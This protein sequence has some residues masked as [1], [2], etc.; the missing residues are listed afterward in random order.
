MIDQ[1]IAYRISPQQKRLWLLQE[2]GEGQPY[3]AQCAVLVEGVTDGAALIRALEHTI[4]RSDILRT[5]FQSSY[6]LTVPVQVVANVGLR[7]TGDFDLRCLDEGERTRRIEEALRHDWLIPFDCQRGPVVCASLMTLYEDRRLLIIT[8]PSLCADSIGMTNLVRELSYWYGVALDSSTVPKQAAEY[9]LFS[10]WQ[11]ELFETEDVEV[12]KSFWRQQDLSDLGTLRLPFGRQSNPERG[13]VPHLVSRDLGERLSAEIASAAGRL[14]IP[15]SAFL[16][17]C[18]HALLG[19]LTE[20]NRILVGAGFSGRSDEEVLEAVGLFAKYLPTRSDLRPRLGV[21]DLSKEI[22]GLVQEIEEWQEW[23]AWDH[24]QERNPEQAETSFFPLCYD[25]DQVPPGHC[26]SGA[27]FSVDKHYSC[28]DRFELKLRCVSR[29]GKLIAEF[30]YNSALYNAA[31]IGILAGQYRNLVEEAADDPSVPI[32]DINLVTDGERRQLLVDFNRAVAEYARDECLHELFQKQVRRVP[33]RVAAVYEDQSLSY[34]ALNRQ[35]NLL[36]HR[37][38]NMGVVPE[39]LVG[40]WVERSV[41]LLVGVI[42]IVKAGAAYLPI[43]PGYPIERIEFILRDAEARVLVTG[44]PRSAPPAWPNTTSIRP[45]SNRSDPAID[46]EQD[47]NCGSMA[48]NLAY[49]IY[50]SGS[51]GEPKGVMVEHRSANN[52]FAALKQAIAAYQSESPLAVSLNAPL[53]FDASVQQLVMLSRGDTLHI[54]PEQ[55][56][57]D[58]KSLRAFLAARGVDVFDCTPS[59]LE[60]LLEQRQFNPASLTLGTVLIAG[61]AIEEAAWRE[62]ANACGPAFYNIYGPTECT[63]DATFCRLDPS[64]ERPNIGRSLA[65]Y[66]LHLLDP[67]MDLVPLGASGHLHIGGPGVT[68]GYLNRPA[69]TAERYVPDPF[70]DLAGSRLYKTGDM[71]RCMPDGSIEFL[72]RIDQQVKVRGYRLELGEIESVLSRHNQVGQCAVCV[73]EDVPGD[74]RVVAYVVPAG[75]NEP[76]AEELREYLAAKLPQYMMPSAYVALPFLLVNSNGKLDRKA[77]PAPELIPRRQAVPPRDPTELYLFHIWSEVLG[78]ANFGIHDN[79]FALGG[80]SLTG[81]TLSSR[82]SEVYKEKM[83]VRTVFDYPTIEEMANY[84]RHEVA[85][86]PPVAL[87]PLQPRGT[88][89][90]FFCVHPAGGLAHVYTILARHLDPELPFYG[91]QAPGLDGDEDIAAT[92]EDMAARYVKEVQRVQPEG[93]YRI[94]GWSFGGVVA[95]EMAQQLTAAGMQVS[96][97]VMLDASLPFTRVEDRPLN[98]EELQGQLHDVLLTYSNGIPGFVEEDARKMSSADLIRLIMGQHQ[99]MAGES[100]L[101]NVMDCTEAHY[102]RWFRKW[103]ANNHARKR[104]RPRPYSGRVVL[105]RGKS[106]REGDYGWSKWANGGVEVHYFDVEHQRF[107]DEPNA[108]ALAAGLAAIL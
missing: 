13:F 102:L 101:A 16:L 29:S 39:A 68:R 25:F 35:A 46:D 7:L 41:D 70:S 104:Y 80:H 2:A 31:E 58:G 30:H 95:Y 65:N 76:A 11:N 69:L 8:V 77:L 67:R 5:T 54:I 59:Q 83:L 103:T 66:L 96:S 19:R 50:T 55:I 82:V 49:V 15:L 86:I 20:Q 94:G 93:P 60:I 92:V 24:I 105:F 4:S 38:R 87:V 73:R 17:A 57:T 12:G 97:L 26:V 47:I 71:G 99:V 78:T 3:R 84:L 88:R 28:I 64:S 14:E 33:D 72:G 45:D 36:A 21:G 10:D 91:L 37:L 89:L 51:T 42:G 63:V 62:L 108:A 48:E 40:L 52:L 85:V 81:V 61:E 98:E 74:K 106:W 100:G 23:F 107:V 22:A 75:D 43:D 1:T 90:P 56:R 9:V 34:G 27:T 32:S 53:A 6:G 79:F 18:W 44:K